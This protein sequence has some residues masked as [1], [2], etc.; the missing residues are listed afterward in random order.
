MA[1]VLLLDDE[2]DIGDEISYFLTQEGHQVRV[3]GA[4]AEFRL[5][6]R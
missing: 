6:Y 1:H 5:A 4:L 2:S 3:S